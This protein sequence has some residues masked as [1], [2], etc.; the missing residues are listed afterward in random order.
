V[1]TWADY[2]QMPVADLVGPATA[3][4]CA[5][6]WGMRTVG[7]LVSH[8]PRR[9]ARRG[10]WMPMGDA[11]EGEPV[12]VVGEVVSVATRPMAARRGTLTEVVIT[13][14]TE[15]LTL[16]F[17]NQ[18]WRERDLKVGVR[19][20]FA[21][22]VG[23]YRGMRQ[24]AHP[25]YQ[26]LDDP[27][28]DA[29]AQEYADEWIPIYPANQKMTSWKLRTAIAMALDLLPDDS[30]TDRATQRGLMAWTQALRAIHRPQSDDDITGARERLA[31]EEAF[32]I[33]A[34]LAQLRQERRDSR[35]RP[36]A[37]T[38]GRLR[39]A[40]DANLP[41]ALTQGQREIGEIL[42]ADL[43]KPHPMHRLLQGDV[44]S[45][46]TIVALR[47]MLDVVEAGGQVAFL[48]PTEVLASQHV[49]TV[50]MMLG[51]LVGLGGIFDDDTQKVRVELLTGLVRGK[52][53]TSIL[54]AIASGAANIVVGTHA[55]L[56]ESVQFSD[57]GLVVIDEQHRFGVDQRAAL[58]EREEGIRPHL[59]VMTATPIP[60]TVAL[61]FFG[62]LEIA[63][64]SELPAMRAEVTTHVV[65]PQTQPAHAARIWTRLEEE[66]A[67]G[68][69]VFVVCPR[70]DDESGTDEDVDT[71]D[72]GASG[73]ASVVST[74]HEL[75]TRYPRARIAE[76]HG[77]MTSEDKAM[78]M[79]GL[80]ASDSQSRIDVVVSTTVI[81][82]GVDVPEATMMIVLD[83]DRFGLSQLHQLRG[84]IGRGSLP[85]VCILVSE[86]DQDSDARA[87]LDALAS[88]RDGF[89]LAELDLELRGE[90]DV[91]G[92]MQSGAKSSLRVLK[93]MS[94]QEL[95]ASARDDVEQW[96]AEGCPQTDRLHVMLPHDSQATYVERA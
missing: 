93:V 46:K 7:D 38:E 41:F 86:A 82:V 28:L 23:A 67:A 69:R 6:G 75:R 34:R 9:Y 17:F 94:D 79:N 43:G 5:S 68:H 73:L 32:L 13:D 18:A 16:T 60:R 29:V 54:E 48:A 2:W 35:A 30:E 12:T 40:L 20:L 63:T 11:R 78:V 71:D 77:R 74:A 83:A 65:N 22:T 66:V 92:S 33:Q 84:R 64:L 53:R 76:L 1:Q 56:E 91:L 89:T 14:G 8:Y 44:G 59:L 21:G 27:D 39:D 57:L 87:R 90:G 72:A 4:A 10:A 50:R 47:A 45:G 61:T 19:G 96:M 58:L 51:S 42:R 62:D 31:Y 26:L 85:G 80:R 95:I 15:R 49:T 52:E 70:I 88:T 36:R 55:L 24:L 3:K 25:D 81:E 37:S